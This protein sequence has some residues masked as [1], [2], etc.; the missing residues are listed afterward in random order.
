MKEETKKQVRIAIVG[1]F[2]VL[3]LI[4]AHPNQ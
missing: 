2:G 1:L 3:A 4:C